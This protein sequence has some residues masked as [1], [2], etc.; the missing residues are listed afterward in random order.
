MMIRWHLAAVLQRKGWTAYRLAKEAELTMPS[1]YKL[2]DPDITPD[3]IDVATLNK[4]C[5]ALRVQPGVLL[6]WEGD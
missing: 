3:R 4:I 5:R 1:A 6:K 2:A